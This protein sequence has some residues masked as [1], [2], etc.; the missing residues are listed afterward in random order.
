MRKISPEE[1]RNILESHKKWLAGEGGKRADLR[2]ADLSG[3]NLRNVNKLKE[4]KI[5]AEK[6]LTD[7]FDKYELCG[8]SGIPDM[9][10]SYD[11]VRTTSAVADAMKLSAERYGNRGSCMT[12][13]NADIAD[14]HEDEN[15]VVMTYIENGVTNSYVRP[16]RSI[17]ERDGW[18]ET[19]WADYKERTGK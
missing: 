6:L 10:R 9:M 7:F 12:D 16:A 18:F 19:V 4:I 13:N 17:P 15:C 8:V 14:R 5:R 3:A 1:L 11:A 2:N